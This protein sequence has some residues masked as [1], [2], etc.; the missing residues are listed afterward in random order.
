MTPDPSLNGYTDADGLTVPDGVRLNLSYEGVV[1]L[2]TREEQNLKGKLDN[3]DLQ[4]DAAGLLNATST[5]AADFADTHLGFV[6]VIRQILAKL[7]IAIQ[8]GVAQIQKAVIGTARLDKMEMVDQAT[9]DIY[10]TWIANGEW[11]K[12][13]G[14]CDQASAN[15]NAVPAPVASG[16]ISG[17]GATSVDNVPGPVNGAAQPDTAVSGSGT[18]PVAAMPISTPAE[19]TNATSSESVQQ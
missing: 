7:G 1:P 3:L 12:V 8:G 13:Q 4:L 14:P 5:P 9:G 17:S 10:C 11:V 15:S 6:E 16:I 18:P 19:T 2:L